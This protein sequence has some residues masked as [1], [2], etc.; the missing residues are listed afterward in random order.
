MTSLTR[1]VEG[2]LFDPV[3]TQAQPVCRWG[4]IQSPRTSP[5]GAIRYVGCRLW[6]GLSSGPPTFQTNVAPYCVACH[7]STSEDDLS[8]LGDCARVERS[9][10]KHYA[11]S[12]T[13]LSWTSRPDESLYGLTK[14]SQAGTPGRD[15][16]RVVVPR[17]FRVLVP[18]KF[19]CGKSREVVVEV[20]FDHGREEHDA[21]DVRE[22][23]S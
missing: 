16:E 5:A 7:I 17:A 19:S 10:K 1:L 6:P 11:A 4:S 8:G 14:F 23:H 15:L 21:G 22:R 2:K 9:L 20:G 3:T 12:V 18:H 13:R